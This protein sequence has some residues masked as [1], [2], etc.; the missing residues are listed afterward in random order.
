MHACSLLFYQ[1]WNQLARNPQ[2]SHH[3][4]C[5]VPASPTWD[6]YLYR[7]LEASFP[8]SITKLKLMRM[9]L[10]WLERPVSDD[11]VTIPNVLEGGTWGGSDCSL[12]K[13][14][15]PKR[16]HSSLWS[17][18]ACWVQN[19]QTDRC[20]DCLEEA[21]SFCWRKST[22]RA[23]EAN[24]FSVILS[25]SM[26]LTCKQIHITSD[27]QVYL[28]QVIYLYLSP[29]GYLQVH[30]IQIISSHLTS[31]SYLHIHHSKV[32]YFHFTSTSYLQIH[33]PVTYLQQLLEQSV[34]K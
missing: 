18:H 1:T 10:P 8:F 6:S 11:D 14:K 20:T 12:W 7:D 28:S 27:L 13:K 24:F 29:T 31:T 34:R 4:A 3:T 32:I 17:M 21:C 26:D 15:S 2:P 33:L 19:R 23:L 5:P 22:T 9:L 16:Y 25:F 30:L